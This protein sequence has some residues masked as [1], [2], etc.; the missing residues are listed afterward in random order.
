[1]NGDHIQRRGLELLKLVFIMLGD[2][3]TQSGVSHRFYKM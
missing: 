3:F 1:M 2:V